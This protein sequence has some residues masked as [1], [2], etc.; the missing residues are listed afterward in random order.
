L[1]LTITAA[2]RSSRGCWIASPGMSVGASSQAAQRG[3][4]GVSQRY[5]FFYA[6]PRQRALFVVGGATRQSEQKADLLRRRRR[7]AAASGL[8]PRAIPISHEIII[9]QQ[10]RWP[11]QGPRVPVKLRAR[12]SKPRETSAPARDE[13]A[14]PANNQLLM[15]DRSAATLSAAAQEGQ[16]APPV[17]A[18]RECKVRFGRPVST[19]LRPCSHAILCGEWRRRASSVAPSATPTRN[20]SA[21]LPVDTTHTLVREPSGLRPP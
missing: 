17:Q 9:Q 7:R 8:Q 4:R 21:S 3:R 20:Q 12:T 18:A 19:V 2:E 13:Q 15:V 1:R 5:L 14:K 6:R 16:E 11:S 10:A